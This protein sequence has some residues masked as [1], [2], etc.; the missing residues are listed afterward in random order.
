MLWNRGDMARTTS[1]LLL[2]LLAGLSLTACATMPGGPAKAT[3]EPNPTLDKHAATP[4]DQYRAATRAVGGHL[5]LAPHPGGQLSDAQKQA[6]SDLQAN[7]G[8]SDGPV[9]ILIAA[10]EPNSGDSQS[11]A[12]A[13]AAVLTKLGVAANQIR[14][15]R[16]EADGAP[17]TVRIIYQTVE[18]IGPDCRKGWDD[19]SATG[20]N[21]ATGHF[22]CALAA[23]LAA[24]IANPRDLDRPTQ[25]TP[26]DATRR[27]V[28]LAKYRKGEQ[29]TAAKD[30]QASGNVSQAVK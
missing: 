26:A 19:F 30:E 15:G 22:G 7:S 5:A 9:V 27:G 16:Y 29:T 14:F 3:A 17:P 1:K 24:M 4:L 8:I 13:T 18:A 21:R 12:N 2:A 11:T 6:L 25:E 23:N 10:S 20:S 28:I